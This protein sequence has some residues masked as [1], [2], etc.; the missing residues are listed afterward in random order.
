MSS[1]FQ[2]R[3][4]NRR[5]R[6]RWMGLSDRRPNYFRET[7]IEGY[8]KPN[9]EPVYLYFLRHFHAAA[10]HQIFSFSTR[11][12]RVKIDHVTRRHQ[13]QIFCVQN[14]P[15]CC[16]VMGRFSGGMFSFFRKLYRCA[17][18]I[19][20]PLRPN[21]MTCGRISVPAAFTLLRK[22]TIKKIKN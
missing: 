7:G 2:P 8:L 5:I 13:P 9:L 11:C 22:L 15:S 3:K 18:L 17:L 1:Y 6:K 20:L 21:R 12:L 10:A 16:H 19:N 14:E 4:I